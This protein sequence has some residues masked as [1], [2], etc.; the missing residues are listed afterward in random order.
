MKSLT[1]L[2]TFSAQSLA[3]DDQG[4]G[5]Q[6][7][8]DRYQINGLLDTARPVM[9]NIEKI[10]SAAG[11]WLSYDIHD[12][13]WGV[14]INTTGTAVAS[15]D[16]TNILGSI[17]VSGTGINELYNSVKVEFPHR[18]LRDSADFV[19][20]E[21]PDGDRNANE[22]D[23]TL[24]LTYDII[25][26]PIQAQLLG[27]IELKQS[28]IDLAIAFQTD[29]SS[30]N[31]KAGD[32][33]SVTNAR[34]AFNAKLF[35]V[36]TSSEIQDD[37]GAIRIEI[38]ALEYD[39]DV[40]S[41]A[42]LFRFTRTDE[43]GIITIGSI[44]VPGTPQVTKVEADVRPRIIIETTVPTG[45]VEA[46]EFWLTDDVNLQ[47]A[48]RSYRLIAIEKPT[49][50]GIFTSGQT[51][52]LEYDSITSGDF[53]V[54]TRGVN[55]TTTGPFSNLSG[56]IDF[57]A[58]QITNAIGPNTVSVD[59][60]GQI[61]TL[62]AVNFL[63]KQVD[64]LFKGATTSTGMFSKIFDIFKDVTG[65]DLVGQ[66]EGG[67]L[68]VASA[69]SVSD[70]GTQLTNNTSG[71]NFVGS[72]VEVTAAGNNV[73]VEIG[74]GDIPDGEKVGDILV[75]N[76]TE[77][78]LSE[79]G[80]TLPEVTP[81]P[82]VDEG[83]AFEGRW[84]SDRNDEN[85][86]INVNSSDQAPIRGPYYLTNYSF[87][88]ALQTGTGNAK[89][90]KSDGTLVE[91][92]AVSSAT[93]D[94]N[95]IELPF[96]DRE[97]GTDYYI[98]VDKG[99]VTHCGRPNQEIKAPI[100]NTATSETVYDRV[101][102]AWSFN[103]PL[104]EV[105]PTVFVGGYLPAPLTL[106]TLSSQSLVKDFYYEETETYLKT[107]DPNTGDLIN[108]PVKA[109]RTI[110][111]KI[112]DYSAFIDQQTTD[113]AAGLG[114]IGKVKN[115]LRQ[116]SATAGVGCPDSYLELSFSAG[117][118]KI[119]SGNLYIK[120]LSDD[121]TATTI[122]VVS[123]KASNEG[124]IIFDRLSLQSG[125]QYYIN[126]DEGAFK[127]VSSDCGVSFN[128]PAKTDTLSTFT[129]EAAPALTSFDVKS[130]PVEVGNPNK[131]NPQSEITLYFNKSV[132]FNSSG[133]VSIYEAG[134]TLHQAIS[135]SDLL[136]NQFINNVL[137]FQGIAVDELSIKLSDT[138]NINLSGTRLI[139]NPT[140]DFK[141][142]TTYYVQVSSGALADSCGT[143]WT[144]I[145]DTSTVSFTTDP[146]PTATVADITN[147]SDGIEVTFDREVAADSGTAK[148]YSSSDV[149]LDSFGMSDPS[150]T[151]S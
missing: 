36:I 17:S 56:L 65:V 98:T 30:I 35:R 131:I 55:A 124:T 61:A 106:P 149:E 103:T 97:L 150:I 18:D 93:I 87:R 141:L 44:G 92:I 78:V 58:T 76:G 57:N 115:M 59:A 116:T 67:E 13:K 62:L 119:G 46:V 64:D 8:A 96:A 73:T 63:M 39:P 5:A 48:N 60:A 29:F 6:T 38:T 54:K 118:A 19:T 7:L 99:F 33:I 146:G 85:S 136:S 100:L 43:N 16:D 27:L 123:G 107:T 50:G 3:Y 148:I 90:Y 114:T 72:G 139:I 31:V 140:K 32:L 112:T 102:A 4:T 101:A 142:A 137:R 91:T 2:N 143:N 111:N 34:F 66:A 86:S 134:G 40:Y 75:W 14:V 47:E 23:N 20:I 45:V 121:T 122:N 28:R 144:G 68:V 79:S 104:Y 132:R 84:P 80:N 22:E 126:Y 12:G 1:E 74:T 26:E 52:T 108:P 41:T 24:N 42:D 109:T 138:P 53:I 10:C 89:L 9:E 120:K 21:I 88:S 37:D 147:D 110:Y 117:G 128:A 129:I 127:H 113:T 11:S 77:W 82:I 125:I 81:E 133:T 51:V 71:I 69:V 70:E 95:V 135:I 94:K 130:D 49:G 151:L 145:S 15:F 25:N 105:T 83:F